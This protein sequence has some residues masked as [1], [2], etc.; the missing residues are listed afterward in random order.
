MAPALIDLYGRVPF[1][2]TVASAMPNALCNCGFGY[3]W[4]DIGTGWDVAAIA[5]AAP[6]FSGSCGQCNEVKCEHM[7][8]IDG[9]NKTIDRTK[10][11]CYDSSKTVVVRTVDAC[12]CGAVVLTCNKRWCCND[13]S[14]TYSAH[15]DISI[16][17]F[18]KLA[19]TKFGVM[20]IKYRRVPCSYQPQSPAPALKNPTPGEAPPPGAR[21]PNE[22]VYVKRTGGIGGTQGG[23]KQKTGQQNDTIPYE[24]LFVGGGAFSINSNTDNDYSLYKVLGTTAVQAFAGP[25]SPGRPPPPAAP[26]SADDGSDSSAPPQSYRQAPIP[27]DASQPATLPPAPSPSTEQRGSPTALPPSPEPTPA[28]SPAAAPA[29]EPSSGSPL[30]PPFVR[31]PAWVPAPAAEGAPGPF[32]RTPS[33]PP[34]SPEAAPARFVRTAPWPAPVAEAAPPP[35]PFVRST[36]VPVPAPESGPRASLAS[37]P[38][39]TREAAPPT[40]APPQ[41]Q[42]TPAPP[43]TREPAVTAPQIASSEVLSAPGPPAA[44][45]GGA[46]SAPA[47]CVDVLPPGKA[48]CK[49]HK[50]LGNCGNEQLKGYC[51]ATC[52]ACASSSTKSAAADATTAGQSA[53]SP[54]APSPSPTQARMNAASPSPRSPKPTDVGMLVVAF[55]QTGGNPNTCIDVVAPGDMSCVQHKEA[56]N[57]DKEILTKDNYCAGTCQRC[58]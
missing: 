10:G 28:R 27:E 15:F 47:D 18:E 51:L 55:N 57:C 26:T 23:V 9:Y 54:V 11:I 13:N 17:A 50:D 1:S 32:V 52:G 31:T 6:E 44:T 3:Q 5:D 56:G 24:S 45:G 2:A 19:N 21:P 33:S 36:P 34:P 20:G 46:R 38:A 48:T 4:P 42:A 40:P 16:W 12:E 37:A 35:P 53:Q 25:D 29:R 8:I 30:P 22:Y 43:P 7:T 39:P 41:K 58:K 49:E 14:Q